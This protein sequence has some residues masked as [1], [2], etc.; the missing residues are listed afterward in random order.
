MKIYAPFFM[1]Q[2]GY[3]FSAP[4]PYMASKVR[5]LGIEAE[6]FSYADAQRAWKTCYDKLNAGYSLAALG[7][8]LGVT[9]ATYLQQHLPFKLVMCLAA[10][11]LGANHAIDKKQTA[12]SVLWH[13][14][15]TLSSAGLNLGFDVVHQ[16]SLPHLAIPYS[17]TIQANVLDE[18]RKLA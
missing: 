10:S 7:Y 11:S 18:F 9:S 12:R 2:F 4:I 5:A 14:T 6:T 3:T 17:P 15:D 13:G 1:G 8:S 16:T